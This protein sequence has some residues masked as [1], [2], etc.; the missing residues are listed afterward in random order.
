MFLRASHADFNHVILEMISWAKLE[1]SQSQST[2]GQAFLPV[3]AVAT[4]D[5]NPSLLPEGLA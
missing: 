2:L 4:E 1:G 3:S 5:S